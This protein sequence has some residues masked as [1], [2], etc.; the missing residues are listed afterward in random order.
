MPLAVFGLNHTTAPVGIREKVAFGPDRLPE[1]VAAVK[2]LPGVNE[3][4]ILSTCNRTELY[5]ELEL[6]D[7]QEPLRWLSGFHGLPEHELVPYL[8][9]HDEPDAVRHAMRVAAGLDSLVLGEPQI[10]GQMKD[11]YRVAAEAGCAGK[12]LN[13]LF[14]SSFAVAKRIRTDTAI[15]SSPV[16]V[17]FA[18]VR[19]AQQI[20]GDLA[21]RTAL[22]IGAGETIEL[23]ALHLRQNH[24]GRLIVANRS[25]DRAQLLA[26][27][28]GGYAIPLG[29]LA[30]HLAEADIVVSATASRLPV[31][32]K[33]AVES[34]LR[35]RRHRPMFLVD[36]AVP[37]D[38][39][40]E[41]A[42]LDDAYLY[43]VDDLDGIIAENLRSRQLA[44]LQADEIVVTE[45]RQFLEWLRANDAARTVAR[46]RARAD[47]TKAAILENARR[48]LAGGADPAGVLT[49]T[50]NKLVAK[51]LHEPSVRLREAGAEGRTEILDAAVEL[52][53]LDRPR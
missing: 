10:L 39:E 7:N 30:Q 34:A 53:D 29:D 26:T 28:H 45:T 9:R 41:I 42:E 4:A 15:G 8:Y 50:A 43:T 36:L 14:Q 17:A 31:L 5:C 11:A 27:R 19:L 2:R 40:P 13:R 38:M 32:G 49:M 24:L 18:A 21:S 48:Q 25:L 22:V 12:I 37:R 46:L 16:S 47:E 33:G 44:A 35:A 23:A 52:F 20:H 6:P 51:L 1:A 3:A